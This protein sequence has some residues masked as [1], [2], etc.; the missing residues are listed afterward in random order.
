MTKCE[1]TV[2]CIQAWTGLYSSN[3]LRQPKVLDTW[4]I[5]LAVSSAL[6]TGHLHPTRNNLS[7]HFHYRLSRARAIEWPEGKNQ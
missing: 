5:K 4:H 1:C 6:R 2:I 3:R 7:T